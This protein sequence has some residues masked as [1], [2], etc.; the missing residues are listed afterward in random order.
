MQILEDMLRVKLDDDG[1]SKYTPNDIRHVQ[2]DLNCLPHHCDKGSTRND[3]SMTLEL[4]Q[5]PLYPHQFHLLC[6]YMRPPRYRRPTY[7]QSRSVQDTKHSLFLPST[8]NK[9]QRYTIYLFLQNALHVSGGTST[10]H[11][12]LK[13]VYTAS[14][15]CQ[16][17]TAACHYRGRVGT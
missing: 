14:G 13:T 10:H 5:A 17:F 9:I 3:R 15:T 4:S 16:N 8:P 11:Q 6:V 12:E 2:A 7:Q 1:A